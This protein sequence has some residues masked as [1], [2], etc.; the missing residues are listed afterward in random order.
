MQVSLWPS[1]LNRQQ[2]YHDNVTITYPNDNTKPIIVEC[3]IREYMCFSLSDPQVTRY[4]NEKG[5]IKVEF[6]VVD[7]RTRRL[8]KRRVNTLRRSGSDIAGR[9]TTGLIGAPLLGKKRK[10]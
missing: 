2:S 6:R 4:A 9:V 7:R 5:E 3:Y 10:K 1:A 8:I